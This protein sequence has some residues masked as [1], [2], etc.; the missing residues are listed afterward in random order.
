[1]TIPRYF[2]DWF[3]SQ[4]NIELQVPPLAHSPLMLALKE[5]EK[6]ENSQLIINYIDKVKLNMKSLKSLVECNWVNSDAINF[7][8]DIFNHQSILSET[9][10][11]HV[12]PCLFL[13]TYF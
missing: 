11:G 6:P 8:Y 12:S 2:S 13:K 10:F 3:Q 5:V 7:F 1:M 9:K 4:Q